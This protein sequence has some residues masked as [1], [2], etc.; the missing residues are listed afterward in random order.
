MGTLFGNLPTVHE[1]CFDMTDDGL[2]CH[3]KGFIKGVA[4]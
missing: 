2:S 3:V 4:A 1:Q